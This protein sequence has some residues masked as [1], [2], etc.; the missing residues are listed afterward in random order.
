M[1]HLSS[2]HAFKESSFPQVSS[3]IALEPVVAKGKFFFAGGD[4]VF[5]KGV[6][7]GTFAVASHG[8]PFPERSVIERDF[9]LMREL[10][11][12]TVR[13]FTVPPR[14]LL[15]LAGRYGLRVI[16]GIPW[17]EHV[18]FLD[19]PGLAREI[20]RT[21]AEGVE[22]CRGHVAVFACLVGNEI[23]PDM[24]R[25]HGPERVRAFL[26]ELVDVAKTTDPDRLVS[27]ANFPSTEYLDVDFADFVSFNVYLHQEPAFR[28]YL[29]HLH[30]LAED[31][32]LVLTEFGIDS[33]RE[34]QEFQAQTLAWQ[35]QASFEM[36]VAGTVVFSWTDEWFTGGFAVEDWAFGLVDR[37]RRKKPAFH[38]VQAYYHAPLPPALPAYP[39]VSVVVCAYNAERTMA[40]C[41]ASLEKLNYPN[42]EVIVVND[43]ST[44]R[45]REIAERYDSIRL[46][47]QE[48]KG[49]SAAR[50][51]GI[52]AA[53]GEIVAF[54]DSDCVA[55]PDWL[56]YLVATFL[57]SGRQAV[58]GPNFPPP[59]DALV[60]SAVAVS[61]GGPTHVL[62][63]DE[64]AEHIP[65]CNMAFRK[66][67]LEEI[68]GF[69]PVFRAAGDDV[70]LC[71]RLQNQGYQI[72]FSPAA[73]VWHF[74]RNTVKA[75]L[76][77]QRGYGKAE[78]QLYFKH[79]Y[80]FNL[81]GQS[82]WLGRIYGDLSSFFLSRRPVI[83][84]GAF[85]RGL[86]QTL[87]EP[88]S[89]LMAFLPLT[90]EWNLVAVLLFIAALL[91]GGYL[92]VGTV[93]LL[94]SV[95]WCATS[96]ARARI[97]PRFNGIRARLLIA[98]LVYLG[99]LV[100][101]FERYRWR[102]RG[103]TDVE[104]IHF[105]ETGQEPEIN[106]RE[107]AFR[108]AYWS[109]QGIEKETLLYG[110]VEFLLPRKYLLALDQGWSGW[111]LEVSRGIWSKAQLKFVSENHG[112]PKRLLRVH[113]AVRMSQP[114]HLA[115]LGYAGLLGV[116]VILGIGELA[117][118]VA[119]GGLANFGVVLY[120]NFRLGRVLYHA[121]EI[122][123][124]RVGLSPVYRN[125]KALTL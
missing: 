74:R 102:I 43:G 27:Y 104:P 66:S 100:R 52:A 22:A 111:D 121:L 57:R 80:R 113:C 30:N 15:D 17:A 32:P 120:Q 69:D 117:V 26:R 18:A 79:P 54:T 59:E 115:L 50:N 87:Y 62:L 65:G 119:L 103:L 13:T 75:Y 14:W 9:A 35:V 29:S 55:D 61:P 82:R 86:F 46:I 101:S 67:A 58:G 70:D 78:A 24:V 97:D 53:T 94:M 108:L 110:M 31:K 123:A 1:S 44:D 118:I 40:P 114:A 48:N 39:K 93:P 83:Y 84:S 2:L 125:G 12:N 95:W 8:A 85:G 112:G 6:T 33:S 19:L 3:P 20:R 7:Y 21:I 5:V 34:G 89:S 36:G 107:R 68:D 72:G 28:N 4:K 10:G 90:L 56:T 63:N 38:A 88:P 47:N 77:Q 124:K 37:E 23:P 92:W 122:T 51:V 96:A 71:W 45:T 64:V 98:L 109:E 116:G 91:G 11:A 25:W 106:W 49:L 41:L 73:V 16:V 42:Y 81:L 60:P 105:A 99:P 76:N